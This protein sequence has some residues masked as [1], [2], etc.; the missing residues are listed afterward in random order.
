MTL[1]THQLDNQGVCTLALNRPERHNALN[2]PMM[3]QLTGQLRQLADD[4]RVRI[5]ILTGNGE[6]FCSG[7]DLQ[8]MKESV[9]YTPEQNQQDALQ[10]ATL[11]R[12]L[13]QLDKP[14]IARINGPAYGGALGLIAACDI[15]LAAHTC[16]FAFSE[17]RLGLIPAM[18]APYIIEAI[19]IRHARRLFLT[20]ERFNAYQ[21]KEL[22]LIHTVADVEQLD[23]GIE[24]QRQALL[25]AG[26]N[27][28]AQ[29]KSM[30]RE[31][32]QLEKDQ[33]LASLIAEIRSSDEGQEGLAAFLEKR[34]PNWV[35]K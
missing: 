27:A 29:C 16:Q 10:L 15:A 13:H 25:Q 11:L 23:E 28:I 8:W 33:Q 21:A 2:V 7:A 34:R 18:I 5:I 32:T 4:K 3:N 35:T 12:T 24:Q 20:A 9:N 6:S 17:V 30:L 1:I 14:T 22:G 31:F 26:P 19:G